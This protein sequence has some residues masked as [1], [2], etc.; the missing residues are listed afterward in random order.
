MVEAIFTETTT[1]LIIAGL[2]QWDYGQKLHIKG[3][4]LPEVAQIHFCNT[5][6]KEAIVM[7]LTKHDD[8]WICEI[9]NV[10]LENNYDIKAWIFVTSKEQGETVKTIYLKVE[11]RAKPQDFISENPDATDILSDVVNKVNQNI[12][13]NAE[14]KQEIINFKNRIEADNQKFKTESKKKFEEYYEELKKISANFMTI[15]DVD[16]ICGGEY[17]PTYDDYN[18]QPITQEEL[19]KILV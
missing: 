18:T 17:D 12:K 10:L 6:Q 13:D 1:S 15:E 14:F 16:R 7:P 19:E 8:A 2:T 9:P 3:L 5:T 11:K 4:E